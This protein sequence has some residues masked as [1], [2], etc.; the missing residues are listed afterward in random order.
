MNKLL[1]THPSA[2]LAIN[3]TL[4]FTGVS[5]LMIAAYFVLQVIR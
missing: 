3:M 1:K 2:W 5:L 4:M